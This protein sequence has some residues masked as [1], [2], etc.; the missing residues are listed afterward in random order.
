MENIKLVVILIFPILRVNGGVNGKWKFK[1]ELQTR[2]RIH[3]EKE[4]N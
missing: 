2:E 1:K 3:Q 4:M